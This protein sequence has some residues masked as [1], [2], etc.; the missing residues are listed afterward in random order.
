MTTDMSEK[1]LENQFPPLPFYFFLA[2]KQIRRVRSIVLYPQTIGNH[3]T[4]N[5]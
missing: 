4:W 2:K 5:L 3:L 1:Y